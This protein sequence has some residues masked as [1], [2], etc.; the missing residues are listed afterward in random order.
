MTPWAVG[1]QTP[2]STEF[3]G[4]NTG[5]LPFP[6]AGDLPDPGIKLGF[7]GLLLLF[8]RSVVSGCLWPH[9]LKHSRFPCPSP[10]PGACSNS[11]A[12]SQWCHPTILSSVIPFSSCWVTDWF[13]TR[14]LSY[15]E[16]PR[17]QEHLHLLVTPVSGI[18]VSKTACKQAKQRL[19]RKTYIK[20]DS[21]YS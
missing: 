21:L 15:Q 11:C 14:H 10:S 7:P 17:A 8:C 9:G 18:F 2:L 5:G 1:R 12:L 20:E 4:Q 3:S 6:F 16:S 13:F 19:K